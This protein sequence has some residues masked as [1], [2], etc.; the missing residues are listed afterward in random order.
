M[1]LGPHA[2][3]ILGSYGFTALVVAGLVL[4]ALRDNRAQKRALAELQ[5]GDRR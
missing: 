1:E 5:G 3:F 2:L 4:N